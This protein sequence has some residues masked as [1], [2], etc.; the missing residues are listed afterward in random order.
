M[1]NLKAT[2]IGFAVAGFAASSA[3]AQDIVTGTAED[4]TENTIT[5]AGRQYDMRTFVTIPEDLQRG[6]V[7]RIE[8]DSNNEE[9]K[10]LSLNVVEDGEATTAQ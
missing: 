9:A 10:V 5:V 3:L 4:W 2:I 8:L 7:V 6:D 1:R